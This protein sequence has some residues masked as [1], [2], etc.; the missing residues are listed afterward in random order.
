MK[1]ASLGS[2]WITQKC[3]SKERFQ[4]YTTVKWEALTFI[5]WIFKIKLDITL[6]RGQNIESEQILPARNDFHLQIQTCTQ[7]TLKPE[8]GWTGQ[9]PTDL[10]C[11]DLYR[12]VA[13]EALVP[14]GHRSGWVTNVTKKHHTHMLIKESAECCL[15][16]WF[17]KI[18]FCGFLFCFWIRKSHS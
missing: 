11:C 8:W 9:V 7:V 3:T 17:S 1:W 10:V 4:K 12:P 2:I 5:Q 13:S 16:T 6:L 18:K 15:I 14:Q